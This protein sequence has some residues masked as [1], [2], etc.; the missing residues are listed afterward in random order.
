MKGLSVNRFYLLSATHIIWEINGKTDMSEIS[1]YVY[2]NRISFSTV[3]KCG[4]K[5][6]IPIPAY[7]LNTVL[8]LF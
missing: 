5:V 7:S 2:L 3:C 4:C 6:S 1:L 8:T